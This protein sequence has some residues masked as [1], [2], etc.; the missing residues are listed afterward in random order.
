M[1]FHFTPYY[2]RES[3]RV[4]YL[5]TMWGSGESEVILY[6]NGLVSIRIG[7]AAGLMDEG[8]VRNASAP[9]TAEV[10]NKLGAFS[11]LR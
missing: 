6:P 11:R 9:T 8:T 5:P 4:D 3:G 7:K 2:D 1:G 10:V